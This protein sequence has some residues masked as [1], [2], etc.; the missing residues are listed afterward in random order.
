M[1]SRI[2]AFTLKTIGEKSLMVVV[3][4]MVGGFLF[5]WAFIEWESAEGSERIIRLGVFAGVLLA[6]FAICREFWR[7]YH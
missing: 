7:G 4:L 3:L 6:F 1:K 5:I 2:N